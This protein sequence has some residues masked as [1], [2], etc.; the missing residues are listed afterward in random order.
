[1]RHTVRLPAGEW[2]PSDTGCHLRLPV[3]IQY[4][5]P[6]LMTCVLHHPTGH[7]LRGQTPPPPPCRLVAL[8]R[9]HRPRYMVSLNAC[10]F[11][12][13]SATAVCGAAHRPTTALE[14]ASYGVILTQVAG[15][16]AAPTLGHHISRRQHDLVLRGTRP[17]FPQIAGQPPAS[18]PMSSLPPR[19]LRGKVPLP[20]AYW[21]KVH[22]SR[23]LFLTTSM[24][25]A[26][27]PR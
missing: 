7:D 14:V 22:P 3:P 13:S 27:L 15:L 25:G 1:M 16:I 26:V 9:L 5:R 21:E 24:W 17:L 11:R 2:L 18:L 4:G 23:R 6:R 8:V 19:T 12:G 10:T 20:I